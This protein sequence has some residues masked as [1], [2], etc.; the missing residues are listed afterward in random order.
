MEE[1]KKLGSDACIIT[2]FGPVVKRKMKI[3]ITKGGE[4]C[5]TWLNPITTPDEMLL[6]L[7]GYSALDCINK[8]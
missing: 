1:M 8:N 5:A 6:P 2:A 3:N 7:A 4:S